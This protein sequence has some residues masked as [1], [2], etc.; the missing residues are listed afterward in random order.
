[1]DNEEISKEI[2]SN[3]L[4]KSEICPDD[5]LIFKPYIGFRFLEKDRDNKYVN[6]EVISVPNKRTAYAFKVNMKGQKLDNCKIR[7]NFDKQEQDWFF[8]WKTPV[9]NG[10]A[11]D[12]GIL[13][14]SIDD[15]RL[16]YNTKTNYMIHNDEW[17][18]E[19]KLNQVAMI[20]FNYVFE[21]P[22]EPYIVKEIN[23]DKT[24]ILLQKYKTGEKIIGKIFG[25]LYYKS[26][27][28]DNY[29]CRNIKDWNRIYCYEGG[30]INLGKIHQ[31]FQEP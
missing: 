23:E 8:E 20:R 28:T 15:P 21:D 6:Y 26:W 3:I 16:Y 17:I 11:N 22:Y 5:F 1:M 24:K 9:Y 30:I 31:K 7:I 12:D 14:T 2:I 13:F 4:V 29:G 10:V 25:K 18:T 27:V 19:P